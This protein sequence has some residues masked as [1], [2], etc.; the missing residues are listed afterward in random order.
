MR[1]LKSVLVV[2]V[3]AMASPV[4]ADGGHRQQRDHR[5]NHGDRHGWD[6]DR[7]GAHGRHH[8]DHRHHG[9]KHRPRHHYSYNYYYPPYPAYPAY[10]YAAPA[11]GVHIVVP[12]IFIPLR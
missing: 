4:W 2:A 3:L 7:H 12:N 1:L 6:R 8:G 9:N 10:G 5:N 11:P